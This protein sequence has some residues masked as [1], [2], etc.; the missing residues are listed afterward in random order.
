MNKYRVEKENETDWNCNGIKK[1]NQDRISGQNV[2]DKCKNFLRKFNW[3]QH[4]YTNANANAILLNTRIERKN[5][6]H[7]VG[8]VQFVALQTN[9]DS[10]QMVQNSFANGEKKNWENV[11]LSNNK[12]AN[13]MPHTDTHNFQWY[14][15]NEHKSAHVY[16]IMIFAEVATLK[17]TQKFIAKTYEYALTKH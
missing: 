2:Q 3:K 7:L 11:Y 12:M 15:R 14:T 5:V 8:S 4:Q 13:T 6:V 17:Y 10:G 1:C 16:V 9:L